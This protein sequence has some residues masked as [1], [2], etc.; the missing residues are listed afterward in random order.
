MSA[1]RGWSWVWLVLAL[2]AALPQWLVWPGLT[3]SRWGG[4]ILLVALIIAVLAAPQRLSAAGVVI[5]SGLAFC[6]QWLFARVL[7]IVL[8]LGFSSS[9]FERVSAVLLGIVLVVLT[10]GAAMSLRRSPAWLAAIVLALVALILP[11]LYVFVRTGSSD[12]AVMLS[13]G[14]G[15]ILVQLINAMSAFAGVWLGMMLARRVSIG[16]PQLVESRAS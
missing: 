15:L 11:A 3:F 8:G 16:R 14:A 2:G 13:T 6:S 9:T 12:V 10:L 4:P 7:T 5:A 1:Y